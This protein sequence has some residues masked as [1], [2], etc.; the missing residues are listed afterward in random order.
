MKIFLKRTLEV[1]GAAA[2]M[3]VLLVGTASASVIGYRSG[4]GGFGGLGGGSGFDALFAAAGDTVALTDFNSA[5]AV[6]SA[7]GLWMNGGTNVLNGTEQSNLLSF[8]NSGGRAVYVTDRSDSGPWSVSTA[9]ILGLF[10]AADIHTGGD[11]GTYATIGS[12]ALVAGVTNIKF[13]TW[14]AV[15][16][17]K[18]S[19]TLL[20]ANGMAAVYNVGLGQ[21]L[22][23]GDTNWQNGSIGADGTSGADD[24]A[25][26]NN[27]VSWL[28]TERTAVPEPG[29]IALFGVALAGLVFV[30]RRKV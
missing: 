23:I 26:A 17:T 3:S 22:F 7:T 1:L 12:N 27:I 13:N 5:S 18:A 24:A 11:N 28:G 25:F 6:S 29:S 10:G 4:V 20:T 8:L 2:L 16:P 19:P 15:D 30:R 9:S 21:L 14:S